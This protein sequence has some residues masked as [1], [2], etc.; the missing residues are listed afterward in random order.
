MD[1]FL[2]AGVTIGNDQVQV[3][4]TIALQ[5]RPP[6]KRRTDGKIP[7]GGPCGALVVRLPV[8]DSE[9]ASRSARF[10]PLVSDPGCVDRT[11]FSIDPD[12]RRPFQFFGLGDGNGRRPDILRAEESGHEDVRVLCLI[13][14]ANRSKPQYQI[15]VGIRF[16]LIMGKKGLDEGLDSRRIDLGTGQQPP[17]PRVRGHALRNGRNG[18]EKNYRTEEF[19]SALPVRCKHSAELLV[20]G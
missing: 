16:Q 15:P 20:A 18:G 11:R 3:T 14:I 9:L 7:G 2:S 13:G 4:L 6:C 12:R 8:A 1:A 5:L 10:L 17:F 19:P